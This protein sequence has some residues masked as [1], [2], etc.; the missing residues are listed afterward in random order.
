MELSKIKNICNTLDSIVVG[1]Q[2]I[3]KTS[4][5]NS[6]VWFIG[7]E[8]GI[9]YDGKPVD[10]AVIKLFFSIDNN[11]PRFYS[12]EGLIEILGG[13][14]YESLVYKN[15]INPIVL[16]KKCPFFIVSFGIGYN[17]LYNNLL[18]LLE[19]QLDTSDAEYNLKRN[20]SYMWA[21]KPTPDITSMENLSYIYSGYKTDVTDKK[22]TYI[23]LRP[24]TENHYTVADYIMDYITGLSSEFW[25]ILFQICVGL[26]ALELYKTVHND[27]HANNV[28]VEFV[29]KPTTIIQQIE[30]ITYKY[31]SNIR[32]AIFDFDRAYSTKINDPNP[33]LYLY[34][35]D[36]GG[37]QCNK[38]VKN[39]DVMQI[40]CNII[41]LMNKKNQAYVD[42]IIETI[43]PLYTKQ[44]IIDFI[45]NNPYCTTN[46]VPHGLYNLPQIIKNCAENS[47]IEITY[48]PVDINQPNTFSLVKKR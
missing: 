5:S 44:E 41:T 42:P 25:L 29:N 16:N 2:G 32:V 27:F 6:D 35:N 9:E 11:F 14:N 12:E 1:V 19:N 28:V 21:G 39:R 4:A 3:N 40:Y 48:N 36:G 33:L 31:T 38:F 8:N 17:C 20:L 46:R 43:A 22:Y 13:L 7:F 23:V 26:Y 18:K 45:N 10:R 47:G 24:F 34:C 15:V 37:Y 30:D